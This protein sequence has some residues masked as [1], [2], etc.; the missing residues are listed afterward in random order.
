MDKIKKRSSSSRRTK[1]RRTNSQLVKPGNE[2]AKLTSNKSE[3]NNNLVP[4]PPSQKPSAQNPSV[5][6]KRKR[7]HKTEDSNQDSSEE[8]ASTKRNFENAAD[9]FIRPSIQKNKNEQRM[10]KLDQYERLITTCRNKLERLMKEK[11]LP[12]ILGL[13]GDS[14]VSPEQSTLKDVL[15]I[16][17]PEACKPFGQTRL[18]S[19]RLWDEFELH[20][21]KMKDQ[22]VNT[23]AIF[24]G[25]NDFSEE[26]KPRI[27]IEES[28]RNW[29]SLIDKA[30]DHNLKVVATM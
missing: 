1:N 25:G 14:T 12:V 22:G 6:N 26:K 29:K 4:I 24:L 28:I 13:Y 19:W 5:K 16:L 20:V 15:S 8:V 17:K 21:D 2:K 27:P 7:I 11:Q 9:A 3:M 18:R 23:L 30:T 10:E